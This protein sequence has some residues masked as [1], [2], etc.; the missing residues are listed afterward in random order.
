MPTGSLPAPY[1]FA[2]LIG[3]HPANDPIPV[4]AVIVV[5]I[6][7]LI[8]GGV[9]LHT[10]RRGGYRDGILLALLLQVLWLVVLVPANSVND[11]LSASRVPAAIPFATLC[12]LPQ[13]RGKRVWLVACCVLWGLLLPWL[14]S[15]WLYW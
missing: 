12:C 5:V 2:G 14:V 15:N 11:L 3:P 9:V 6:P 8:A 10:W 1:P 4:I 7:A 13:L